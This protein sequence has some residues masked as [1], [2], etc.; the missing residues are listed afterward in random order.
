MVEARERGVPSREERFVGVVVGVVVVVVVAA[1]SSERGEGV[2]YVD[3]EPLLLL[4]LEGE[5]CCD[6]G[7]PRR[8]VACR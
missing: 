5:P 7:E 8:R 1:A 6:V 3:G 4:F 2:R